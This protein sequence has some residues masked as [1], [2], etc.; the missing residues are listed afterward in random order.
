VAA[1]VEALLV[2]DVVLDELAALAIAAPPPAI[3][4]VTAKAVTTARM[5]WFMGFTSFGGVREHHRTMRAVSA[6]FV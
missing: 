6:S 1:G 3:A 5:R 2:V 4:A